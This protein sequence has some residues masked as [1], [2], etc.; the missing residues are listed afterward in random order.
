MITAQID[1]YLHSGRTT[2]L[3]IASVFPDLKFRLPRAGRTLYV[4]QPGVGC[5]GVE[6]AAD[7]AYRINRLTRA[8]T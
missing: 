5:Y 7:D 4:E 1:T 6:K 8:R 2:R 3:F